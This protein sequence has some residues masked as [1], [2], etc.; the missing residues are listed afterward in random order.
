M[1]LEHINY[2]WP[3]VLKEPIKPQDA[4]G[5]QVQQFIRRSIV[6]KATPP[7]LPI[8]QLYVHE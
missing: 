8:Y 6:H 2:T 4:L 3:D 7:S 5:V 1:S